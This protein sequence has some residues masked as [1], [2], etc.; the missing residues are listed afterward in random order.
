MYLPGTRLRANAVLSRT[1]PAVVVEVI[2]PSPRD[3]HRDRVEKLA[4]YA[5]FG[6][7]CYWLLDPL[8][9]ILEVLELGA[10]GRYT[11]AA[12]ASGGKVQAPA[13]EGL[14]LDLDELWAEVDRLSLEES[15]DTDEHDQPPSS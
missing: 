15:G 14:T 12:S 1:P 5:R 7:R 6:V 13:C 4:D 9:R 11:I 3:A 10:D 2:S 8:T